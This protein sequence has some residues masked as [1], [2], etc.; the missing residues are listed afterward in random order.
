MNLNL[1]KLTIAAFRR[2]TLLYGIF[3]FLLLLASQ[4][5]WAQSAAEGKKLYQTCKTCHTIGGGR[6]VG[7]DLKGV[8]E[9]REEDWLIKFINNSQEMIQAGDPTA[10]E[11]FNDYNQV[12]MPPNN[13]SDDEVR[14]ILKYIEVVGEGG[15]VEEA[16]AEKETQPQ[17]EAEEPTAEKTTAEQAKDEIDKEITQR[18]L[19]RS[20]NYS[21]VFWISLLL[22]FLSIFD[23]VI[24]RLI[25]A[26]F[27][28]VVIILIG[29]I[30][31]TEITVREAIA[32]G[33]Q[34]GYSPDQ[35][36]W[37]SH[38]VHVQQNKIDCKY[39][40]HIAEDSKYAGIPSPDL[41]MNCHNVIREGSRTGKEEIAKIHDAIE[42]NEPIK[43]IKVHNLPDHVFFSHAQHVNVGQVECQEC[44]GPVEEMHRIEQ[45]K[46]LSMGW[47]INCHRKAEVVNFE[48]N[49]FYEAYV[50]LHEELKAGD[51]Q[52][53]TVEDIGGND[54]QKCHY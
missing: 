41:C 9:R 13:F 1:S 19:E 2:K 6:L 46:D 47:C 23:L 39:C 32:L 37:F 35:P 18:M 14:S 53:V 54:C 48:S 21:P 17:A 5:L 29:V 22:I 8:T 51:I 20:R 40:H 50:K 36:I 25:K 31:V 16:T 49:A 3:M 4:S 11:L 28:H 26:R 52:K 24:T 38:Q 44:H 10:V 34:E 30:I 27:V 12:P 7:P 43:W 15:S 33:R 45:V 42:N